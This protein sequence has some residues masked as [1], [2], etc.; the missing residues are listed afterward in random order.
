MKQVG[1]VISP[2]KIYFDATYFPSQTAGGSAPDDTAY[3]AISWDNNMD[4]PTKNVVRDKFES[5]P[6]VHTQ[7]TDSGT[8]ANLFTINSASTKGKY[9]FIAATGSDDVTLQITNEVLTANRTHYHQDGD[10]TL[11]FLSDIPTP[12]TLADIY[13]IGCIYTEITGVNPNT[14][15]GFGTWTA[16]GSGKVLVGLDSGDTDFDTAEETGGSKTVQSSAQTFG[17]DA[18]GTHQ[19]DAT[20]AG[21][22]AGTIADHT[23]TGK[24]AQTGAL[25]VVTGKTHS[26]TGAALGTHQHAAITA[27][28]PS[29]T[30]TPGAATSVVQPYIVVHFWKRTA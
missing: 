18:L 3:D 11:A 13:P 2:T 30:N 8:T 12:L 9:E 27:G 26:F 21:T 24:V 16:F 20:T 1:K 23:T 19:H 22:P 25:T 14:T 28:T 15:F 6:A 5:L 29:G 10:G 4:A 7:N 17:G